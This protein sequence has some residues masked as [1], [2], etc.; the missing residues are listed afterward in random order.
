MIVEVLVNFVEIFV[1][2]VKVVE[3]KFPQLDET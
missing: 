1:D 3:K 2:Y